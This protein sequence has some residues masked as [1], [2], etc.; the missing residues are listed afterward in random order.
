MADIVGRAIGKNYGNK[1]ILDGLNFDLNKGEVLSIVGRSGSGK[2]TL[3]K[4]LAGI[5]D[6]YQGEVF[7]DNRDIR[8]IDI[9]K[10]K[11]ILM[12]Q[13]AELFPH[14]NIYDNVAF[15]LKMHGKDRDFIKK[16][17]LKYLDLVSLI[18]HKDKYPNEL[19]GGERQRV[20]LIRSLI[21]KPNMLLL[22]EPF[23]ALDETLRISLR[24]ETFKIIKEHN[25]PT[26][27][28]SHDINEAVEVSDKMAILKDGKFIA[29]DSPK[30]IFKNPK[31]ISTAKFIFKDN[32]IDNYLIKK[33][34]IEIIKGDRYKIKNKTY[35]GDY[36]SYLLE[37]PYQII[38]D[39][40]CEYDIGD[41]VDIDI[42]EK[43]KLEER[44]KK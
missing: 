37:G 44:W 14:M 29:Y 28:V 33:T 5:I 31:N 13:D 1:V 15:G 27:F 6:D 9:R 34:D 12:F 11:F 21:L 41:L 36:Y 39:S 22:D 19:S 18:E 43:T 4:I 30:N 38:V 26:L 10:R 8:T 24:N 2:S 16:E 40:S 3:L 32:I 7:F 20:S 25:I 35:K 23:S 42:K 17:T